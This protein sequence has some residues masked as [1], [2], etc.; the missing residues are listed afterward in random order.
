M[1]LK[2]IEEIFFKVYDGSFLKIVIHLNAFRQQFFLFTA[3][4]AGFESGI[5]IH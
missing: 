5:Q 4:I 3:L 2:F 1:G